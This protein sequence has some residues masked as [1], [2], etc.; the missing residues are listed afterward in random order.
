MSTALIGTARQWWTTVLDLVL[1]AEC[2]GC[3]HTGSRDVVQGLCPACA[4][5]LTGPPRLVR[6]QRRLAGLSGVHALAPYHEPLPEIVIA[7]KERGRI[8][9]ARPLGRQL[10]RAAL[11]AAGDAP[12]FWLI[13][14]PSAARATRKRGHDPVRR[15]ARAAA[16]ELREQ[17]R[18]ANVLPAL[19]H[20]RA[21]ADQA[22]LDRRQRAANL[23]G[24][25]AVRKCAAELLA[26][27]PAVLVDDVLT[28]GATLAEAVRALRAAGGRPLGAAVLGATRFAG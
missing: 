10:A 9:L 14:A 16:R 5:T 28:S 21:V 22:G 12:E 4:L 1:P 6:P 17:G 19:G 8:D 3:G 26:R 15:M 13:P 2:A 18:R 25:L 27:R 23:A 20:A 11:A 24:A 7:H